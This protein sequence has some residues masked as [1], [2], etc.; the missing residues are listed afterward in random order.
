MQ[1]IS[2]ELLDEASGGRRDGAGDWGN[3]RDNVEKDRMSRMAE[4]LAQEEK[5]CPLRELGGMFKIGKVY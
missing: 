3:S 4:R 1:T 2:L 5:R